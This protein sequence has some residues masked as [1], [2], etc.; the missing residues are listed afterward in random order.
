[1]HEGFFKKLTRRAKYS[2]RESGEHYSYAIFRR[3][4]QHEIAEDCECRCVYCDSHEVEMGG[5]EAMEIDHFR[6]HSIA[7]FAG[8]KDDPNNFH[9]ACSRCNLLKSD[10]WPST[11]EREPHD[12]KVGFV[13]PFCDGRNEYFD[14]NPDGSLV[15]LKAPATYL[16]KLLALNRAHLRLLRR[17]RVQEVQLSNLVDEVTEL[18]ALDSAERGANFEDKLQA[19]LASA[20]ALIAK[21]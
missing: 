16:I 11:D 8:Q 7:K 14:L 17:R 13:D 21:D 4:F 9:H 10:H 18:C 5:R 19:L 15:P 6:P 12:G 2:V 3:K 20:K 1:M